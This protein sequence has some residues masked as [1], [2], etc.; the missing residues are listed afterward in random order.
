MGNENGNHPRNGERGNDE[1]FRE[2]YGNQIGFGMQA[3]IYARDNIA[4][5]VFFE[6]KPK[7]R[8]YREAYSLAMV[9]E[10]GIP[11][12]KVHGIESFCNRSVLL[13]DQVRGVSLYDILKE[14][15]EKVYEAMDTMV[16]LQMEMHEKV[17]MLFI[18]QKKM[19]HGLITH[20][21]GLSPEEKER[22]Y[23]MLYPLP[24]GN[25]ICHGD[26]QFGNILFD[27]ESY[28]IIDWELI[29]CGSPLVDAC[30]SYLVYYL[31]E[32]E[33]EELY[34]QKYCAVSGRRRE[35]ILPWLHVIAGVYYGYLSDEGKKIVR[36]LF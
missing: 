5:K 27:G 25:S 1:K 11:A 13:M 8:A 22:L 33:I 31:A 20:S 7:V 36:S 6:G 14:N 21:P 9:E 15:P 2:R 16:Q 19:L 3:A 34:L 28:K 12:P 30:A 17:S 32:R 29:S 18:P 10:L 24:E 35:E 26:F 23:T 4:A